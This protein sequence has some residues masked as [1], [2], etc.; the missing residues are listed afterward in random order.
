MHAHAYIHAH[1]HTHIS[2]KMTIPVNLMKSQTDPPKSKQKSKKKAKMPMKNFA[3]NFS[4][5]NFR[6]IPVKN[7]KIKSKKVSRK[8]LNFFRFYFWKK[9]LINFTYLLHHRTEFY[10]TTTAEVQVP[11]FFCQQRPALCTRLCSV[12]GFRSDCIRR[13]AR[14]RHECLCFPIQPWNRECL[15]PDI[16][17]LL[18]LS[19]DFRISYECFRLYI[20]P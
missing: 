5:Q 14:Y 18:P 10:H 11:V 4:Y 6:R 8:V 2:N 9:F 12:C 20:F 16:F 1:A 19:K 7:Q 13:D 3:A 17:L 15:N